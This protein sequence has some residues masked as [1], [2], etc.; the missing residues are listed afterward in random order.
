MRRSIVKAIFYVSYISDAVSYIS[1]AVSY[2]SAAVSYISDAVSYIAD[3]VS[4]IADAVSY[5][6]NE[7][8]ACVSPRTISG[9]KQHRPVERQSTLFSRGK[10]L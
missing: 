5:N 10:L 8:W 2:I 1:A 4:Y 6:P 3:A 9:T 7:W